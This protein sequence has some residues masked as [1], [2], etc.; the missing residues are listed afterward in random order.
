VQLATFTVGSIMN[1]FVSLLVTICIFKT[2]NCIYYIA[3]LNSSSNSFYNNNDDDD[4]DNNN[5][6]FQNDA[7]RAT[8]AVEKLH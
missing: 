3:V 4:D 2:K 8:M 7:I 6:S 5:N 1:F